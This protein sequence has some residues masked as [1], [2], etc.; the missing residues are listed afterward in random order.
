MISR[1]AI[2]GG[3]IVT[4]D[5]VIENGVALC[6]DSYIKAVGSSGTVEP[7]PGSQII[8]ARGRVVMPGFID[9]HFHGSGGDDVMANGVEGIRRISRALLKFGTTGYLATTIAAR[10]EELMRS[11]EDT[12]AAEEDDPFAAEILGLHIEGPYINHK[13]KG[14]QPEWGIRDPNFDECSQLLGAAAG[15]IKIMTVA[16]ELPGALE[17]I[18]TLARAGVAPSLGHSEADYD[19]ALAA[20]EAGAT[21]A[22]HLFNAMSGVHHRKP[23]LA[24]AALN[25]PGLCAEMICDG[26]HVNPRMAAMAWKM[27]GRDGM[28]LI[29]DATAAQGVGDG[30]FTLGDFQI[31]VRG[32]LCT[33]MDGV[34]IAGSVLTM[35][36]AAANAIAFTGMNLIDAAH[37]A[38]LAPAEVCGVADR[39][40]SIEV[41]KDADLAILNPDFSV[42]RTIRAGVV[43]Y[44][45]E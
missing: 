7:E 33:L 15:R 43:A 18:R 26:V 2:V 23:G 27:K 45:S 37:T 10:H 25:E 8:D 29:T 16:P 41:G 4:R 6:E 44:C 42:W 31:Q 40:G 39:K 19:T 12:T 21:R 30:V 17:L 34:T 22:T 13:F 28:A 20:I 5:E 35:N 3:N 14:A 36:R 38:A 32:P 1:L 9:T 24:V 11:V